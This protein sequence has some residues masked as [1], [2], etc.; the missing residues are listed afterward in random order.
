V[1]ET[2]NKTE[3]QAEAAWFTG[4]KH[5]RKHDEIYCN[6][7]KKQIKSS[8]GIEREGVLRVEKTWG[9]FSGKDGEKHSF[10]LCEDCYDR[11]IQEFAIPVEKE[12]LTELL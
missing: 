5:M 9:Y 1:K 8:Q 4:R 6:K 2:K 7:C 10:D 3:K 11:M 12:E